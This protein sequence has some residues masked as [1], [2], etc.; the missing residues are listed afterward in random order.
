MHSQ[1]LPK[2]KARTSDATTQKG[3]LFTSF[4]FSQGRRSRR[5]GKNMQTDRKRRFCEREICM[6]KASQFLFSFFSCWENKIKTIKPPPPPFCI[7]GFFFLERLLFLVGPI[8]PMNNPLR[9]C[10]CTVVRKHRR[11]YI[12]KVRKNFLPQNFITLFGVV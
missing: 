9:R 10:M 2:Q 1:L 8:S 7:K 4:Y 12:A 11:W 5:E 6:T 3:T